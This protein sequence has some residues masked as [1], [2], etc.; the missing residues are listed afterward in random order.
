MSEPRLESPL[1]GRPH[2]R[3]GDAGPGVCGVALGERPFLGH[4]SLRG[5]MDDPAF[6]NACSAV[7]GVALPSAPNTYREG[8]GVVVGWMGPTEWLVLVAADAQSRWLAALREALAGLHA[9]VVDLSGGQTL[10]TLVGEHASDVLAKGSTLDLHPRAAGVGFCT[11]SLLA[12]SAVFLRV[13]EADQHF[14][15]VVRRSFADYLW[16]WL[17]DASQEY[18]CRILPAESTLSLSASGRTEFGN[19]VNGS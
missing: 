2:S 12:S 19:V 4:F 10:I 3:D 15:I 5:K 18:G 6:M 13:V 14:E 17:V 7:L 8:E 11:R 1:V 9:G 16:Q